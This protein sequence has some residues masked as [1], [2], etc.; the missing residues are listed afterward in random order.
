MR[1]ELDERDR[2]RA[3]EGIDRKERTWE[4]MKSKRERER[5]RERG[6]GRRGVICVKY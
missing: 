1:R 3:S 4:R 6:S 2:E 5:E